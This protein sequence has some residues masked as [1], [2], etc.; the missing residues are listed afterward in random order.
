[1]RLV[2]RMVARELF[3]RLSSANDSTLVAQVQETRG[4]SKRQYFLWFDRFQGELQYCPSHPERCR[5]TLEIDAGS[6]TCRDQLLRTNQQRRLTACARDVVLQAHK[7]PVIYF[8]SARIS[9]KA[10]RGLVVEGKLRVRG[11]TRPHK[12]NVVVTPVEANY[13][14]IEGD[15]LVQL[16]AFDISAPSSWFG[17]LRINDQV[18]I[19]WHLYATQVVRE[20]QPPE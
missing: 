18:L 1:M 16:S 7:H 14:E 13:L 9:V 11:T 10:L 17:L 19:H 20:G 5:L 8:S 6:L 4:L 15:S 12:V 2:G 3:Y